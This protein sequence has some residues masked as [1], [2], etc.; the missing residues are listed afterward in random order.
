M[1][2][3]KIILISLIS[4]SIVVTIILSVRLHISRKPYRDSQKLIKAI[5]NEI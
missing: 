3:A 4:V 2:K 5:K 1:K